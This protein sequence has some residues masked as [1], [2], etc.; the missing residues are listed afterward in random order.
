M[1]AGAS[2][3]KPKSPDPQQAPSKRYQPGR[4]PNEYDLFLD[5]ERTALAENLSVSGIREHQ[6]QAKLGA[7]TQQLEIDGEIAG[8]RL[9]TIASMNGTD[10]AVFEKHATHRGAIVYVTESQGVIA[11]IPKCIGDLSKIR[12]RPVNAPHVKLERGGRYKPGPDDAGNYILNSNED[13]CYEN[14]AAL[15]NEYI[16]WS[17][18]ANEQAGPLKISV[19]QPDRNFPPDQ[20]P[21]G[22]AGTL[23][24]RCCRRAI[25][26][27]ES[28]AR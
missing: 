14:V 11:R 1:A 6:L 17:L 9:L 25:R 27:R 13:P 22:R 16:G 28:A 5:N 12:P 7:Q 21:T 15:G 2:V 23:G 3:A 20:S 26:S 24:A 10:T 4:I 19:F 8:W 18:V